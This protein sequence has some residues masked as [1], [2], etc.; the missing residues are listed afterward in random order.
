MQMTRMPKSNDIVGS[1]CSSEEYDELDVNCP[2]QTSS[3]V[4]CRFNNS[5]DTFGV[6][7]YDSECGLLKVVEDL[8]ENDWVSIASQRN[9]K[10]V[11][12]LIPNY[13]VLV[14]YES[15]A[16]VLLLPLKCPSSQTEILLHLH[17]DLEIKYRP[18]VDFKIE[19]AHNH[20]HAFQSLV[21]PQQSKS[22]PL[23][24][25]GIR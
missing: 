25:S 16:Q 19:N 12:V 13:T 7:Y 3:I 8:C 17:V 4:C 23:S 5:F 20:F 22:A 14:I 10:V 15:N 1:A 6:A 18:A 21:T 9:Y 11:L 24:V 2:N